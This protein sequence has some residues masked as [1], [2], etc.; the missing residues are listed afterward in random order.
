MEGKQIRKK[1]T[2]R[3]NIHTFIRKFKQMLHSP[4]AVVV[5][6]ETPSA[7]TYQY[8]L[9]N[10]MR[11]Q[12]QWYED[13]LGSKSRLDRS[14]PNMQQVIHTDMERMKTNKVYDRKLN[15]D[16]NGPKGLNWQCK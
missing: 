4:R 13:V 11:K 9:F 5:N 2:P 1:E 15:R 12:N 8:V 14:A 6:E 7:R 10:N 16:L 3:T